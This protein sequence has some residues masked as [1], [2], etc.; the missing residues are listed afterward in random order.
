MKESRKKG[1]SFPHSPCDVYFSDFFFQ[2]N[3]KTAKIGKASPG[4]N[5]DVEPEYFFFFHPVL[6]ACVMT[7]RSRVREG[8]LG[9]RN[10]FIASNKSSNTLLKNEL[11]WFVKKQFCQFIACTSACTVRLGFQA[12]FLF[13]EFQLQKIRGMMIK[14]YRTGRMNSSVLINYIH[15]CP[16]SNAYFHASAAWVPANRKVVT[17]FI[18][19]G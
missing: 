6:C 7:L 19:K 3:N 12:M 14:N 16:S 11:Y 13:C 4:Q 10:D 18:T 2:D 15:I 5:S 8:Q 1:F 17:G 9:A